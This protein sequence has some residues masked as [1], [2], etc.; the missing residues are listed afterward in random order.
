M[1]TSNLNLPNLCCT[2]EGY[3]TKEGRNFKTLKQRWFVL[4]GKHLSYYENKDVGV[5]IISESHFLIYL[6]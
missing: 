3:L 5:S 6:L 1:K 2:K 4:S